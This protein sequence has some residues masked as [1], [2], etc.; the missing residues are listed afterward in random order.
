[1][2]E[3][4]TADDIGGLQRGGIPRGG[5]YTKAEEIFCWK[6]REFGD[7]MLSRAAG[8]KR[9]VRIVTVKRKSE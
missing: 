7:K 5:Q 6:R 4:R 3:P 9:R 8:R 2:E 1:M